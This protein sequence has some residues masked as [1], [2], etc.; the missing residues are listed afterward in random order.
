[1]HIKSE[2]TDY[3]QRTPETGF[4]GQVV[5]ASNIP[6]QQQQRPSIIRRTDSPGISGIKSSPTQ[7]QAIPIKQEPIFNPTN[8]QQVSNQANQQKR[9]GTRC[10]TEFT[11]RT[12]REEIVSLEATG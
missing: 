12:Y 7:N 11:G 6:R 5:L 2:P 3:S 10:K 4:S 8:Y 9:S 1:M